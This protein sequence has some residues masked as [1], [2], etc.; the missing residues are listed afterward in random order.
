VERRRRFLVPEVVQTSAMD[1][2]PA[3]LA[4][5]LADLAERMKKSRR[6]PLR[7]R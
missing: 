7:T 3:G 6:H 1:G 5:N 2:G 4:A